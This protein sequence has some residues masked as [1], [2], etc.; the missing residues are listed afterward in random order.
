MI[1]PDTEIR[2]IHDE[3]GWGVVATRLIPKGSITW[4]RDELDRTLRPA[5]V[6]ALGEHYRAIVDKYTFVDAR[7]DYVLCWDNA[8]FINHSCRATCMSPGFEFEIAVRDIAPGEELTD[9]YGSL[10]SHNAFVCRCGVPECRRTI[11]PT[12]LVVHADAWDRLLLEAFPKIA[13]VP[14]PLW[15][16]V[17]EKAQVER[18]LRGEIPM[19]SC[20]V[21]YNPVLAPNIALAR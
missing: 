6:E 11:E 1:H 12:D 13:D 15:P 2:H 10:N 18:V 16:F 14:Q 4:A 8:R 9:D 19:P 5:A 3:I 7:G 17:R 21:N 20:R